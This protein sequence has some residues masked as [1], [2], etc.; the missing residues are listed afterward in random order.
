MLHNDLTKESNPCPLSI[1]DWNFIPEHSAAS[2]AGFERRHT[3]APADVEEQILRQL[4]SL[5][6]ENFAP[7]ADFLERPM[8]RGNA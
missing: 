4:M 5:L 6:N 3:D 7:Y 8:A 2:A 1:S